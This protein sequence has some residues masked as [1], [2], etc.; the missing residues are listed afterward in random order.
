MSRNPGAADALP[1]VENDERDAPP[2]PQGVRLILTAVLGWLQPFW[3]WIV[4]T[5]LTVLGWHELRQV[6]LS[7]VGG[8][9]SDTGGDLVLALLGLTALNLM[10]FGLYDLVALGPLSRPPGAGARFSVGVLSFAWS[11][12]LTVGP[13][14][15]PALR[16]WLYRPLGVAGERSRSALTQI[17]AAFSLSLL[18]WCGASALPLPA[19]LDSLTLR[20]V[21]ALP[22]VAL[23]AAA[24]RLLPRLRRAPAVVRR[25]EGHPAG[26]ACVAAFDWLLAWSVFHLALSGLHGRIEPLLSLRAFFVGQLVGLVSFVPGGLG[27][28]DAWWLVTLSDAAGGH[29]KVL[30]ALLLYRCVYYVLPWFFAT[31]V[32]AGRLVR[33][34]RRTNAFL[35]SAIASYTFLCGVVL[36]ASAATPTLADRMHFLKTSVPLALVEISHGSSVL[37]GFLL[38]VISRGLARGYRSSHRLALALFLAG[39]LTTFLKGL[40]FEEALLSLAAGVILLVFRRPF[41]R[42]GRL[43]PPVEFIVSVG[44]FAV[45]LFAAIGFGSLSAV[46]ETSAIYGRFGYFAYGERFLRGLLLLAA[47]ASVAALHFTLRA[48]ASEFIPDEGAIGRALLEVRAWARG[49]NAM[50]V[51]CG[52]QA[53][54]RPAE[55]PEEA[56]ETYGS[57]GGSEAAGGEETAP[58]P[59]EGFIAYRAA[60]RFLIAYSDPVCP[61]GRERD[62]LGALLDFSDASDRDPILY[63]ISAGLLPVAHDFGFTF[64]KLGEEAIV[65]LSRFDLKGNKAKTWRHA[66]NSV[67]KEGGH[68]EI[69]SGEAVPPLLPA[70]K[71]VS[72]RWLS[73]KHLVEKRF[74]IGRFD[75]AYLRRFPCALVRDARE[76]IVGFANLLEGPGGGEISIDLMRYLTPRDEEGGLRNVMD[77]LFLKLML[78]GKERGF[79]RFNLGM[80]PLAAVGEERTARPVEKLANVLF[81]V[82]EHWYNYQG[83]RRYKEKFDP[84]WEPRYMAYRRPWDWPWAAAT[85]AVLIAGGWRALIFPRGEAE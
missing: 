1:V 35:R 17:L 44:A 53:I 26:L 84:L 42:A 51:A 25:W 48:R 78:Y 22:L 37:L 23:A 70:L 61:P 2:S 55:R 34:G 85:T 63:Q 10:V 36:L 79:S 81:R 33:T 64:F 43:R 68:F 46:P 21:L 11:N 41:E 3:P 4:L 73:E 16:L 6:D 49:T 54:F 56:I 15:G 8:L 28:A 39:A 72:D 5:V 24:L 76:Q 27:T 29:D 20:I 75:A 69:V 47:G 60:G 82:G 13:L 14:A 40:D 18:A 74:S 67:E 66:I 7:V 83:L 62:L 38:L 57:R 77:Y 80:T 30:A 65:E 58:P 52:D 31:L 32:L 19:G 71:R 45:V 9:L 59:P 12:F 50:L